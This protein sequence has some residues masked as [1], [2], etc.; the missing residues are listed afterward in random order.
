MPVVV[1][2]NG[3]RVRFPDDMPRDQIRDMIAKKFPQETAQLGTGVSTPAQ[4]TPSIGDQAKRQLGL[5]GRYVA[6]GLAGIADL[7][8]AAI[9][10]GLIGPA[11][12]LAGLDI[13]EVPY[14]SRGVGKYLTELGVPEPQGGLERVVGDVSRALSGVGGTTSLASAASKYAPALGAL[15]KDAA[16]QGRAAIGSAVGAGTT[17]EMGGGPLAQLAAGLTGGGLA[18]MTRAKPATPITSESLKAQA[19]S[20]YDDATKQG[21]VLTPKFTDRFLE[22]V[23]E[24]LPQTSAGKMIAGEDDV[25]KIVTRIKGLKGKPITL[26]EAQEIDEFLGDRIDDFTELG[27][28]KKQGKKLLEI[29][30]SF[31]DLIENAGESDV[32]GSKAGFAALKEGRKLWSRALKTRDIERIIERASMMDQPANG[33]KSGFRTLLNNPKR[34]RGFTTKEEVAAIKDAAKSGVIGEA[35]RIPG[36]R[37]FPITSAAVGTLGGPLGGLASTIAAGTAS[38]VSRSLRERYQFGKAY[39]ALSKISG[40]KKSEERGANLPRSLGALQGLT[41]TD[42]E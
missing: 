21:G 26:A 41:Q 35:L 25:S 30:S 36:S 18:S 20:L 42:E 27:S 4:E 11:N 38:G 23:D 16:L 29:Q 17:R 34:M 6:E 40:V 14:A 1:M 32:L 37:L 33:I 13:P 10:Y 8:N 7:P 19:S 28:L 31:R 39:K 22:E 3:D 24:V 12:A 5:T 15:A 9:N 2:P